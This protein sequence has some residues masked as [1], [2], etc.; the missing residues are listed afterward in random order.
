V[1]RPPGSVAAVLDPPPSLWR[2]RDFM[3]L[4]SGQV[5]STVGVRIA[6]LAF[7]LLVLAQTGS[8]AIAGLVGFVQTLPFLLWYL[9]AGALVDRWDRKKVMLV[10]DA[11]RALAMASV[12]VALLADRLTLAQILAAALV[13]GTLFVFFQLAEGAALPHVVPRSQLPAALAQNQARE[14][15]AELAGQPLGGVLF[16]IGHALPFTANVLSYAVSFATLL[17]I[18]PAFQQRRKEPVRH[19]FAEVAEGVRWLWRQQFLR[20]LVVLIG[21]ANFVFNAQTLAL[22]VRAQQLGASSAMVGVM[23]A[24]FGVGAILGALVAPALSRKL[25]PVLVIVGSFWL[26]AGVFA[27]FVLPGEPLVLGVLAGIGALV[28]PLFNV[29]VSGYRYTLTPDHLQGRVLGAGRLVAWGAL[30]LGALA[31]GVL[32]ESI[33]AVTTFLVLAAGMAAVAAVGTLSRTIRRAPA[34]AL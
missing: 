11:G 23:F 29:V 13:E 12:V 22:I 31:G 14:Q 25:P 7:P 33:G 5:V 30:P 15:G 16:G 10:A 32:V 1:A 18:R 2:N 6:A 28:G 24:F 27:S 21:A 4:W 34:L 8:P 9:P 20:A 26:W 19:L 17:L 3:L